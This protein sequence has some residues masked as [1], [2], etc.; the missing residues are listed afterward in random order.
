MLL[1]LTGVPRWALAD[2]P[3]Q[4]VPV[5]SHVFKFKFLLVPVLMYKGGLKL[6]FAFRAEFSHIN[7][8]SQVNT[9]LGHPFEY[10]FFCA[11]V[12]G[13][14]LVSGVIF[15]VFNLILGQDFLLYSG[16]VPVK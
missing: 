5:E 8:L 1:H 4:Y 14:L 11:P 15:E 6:A 9:V 2:K 12:D 3:Y 7:L 16:K 10:G 13:E